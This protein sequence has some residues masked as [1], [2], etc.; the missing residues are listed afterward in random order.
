MI[1]YSVH[2]IAVILSV[3]ITYPRASLAVDYPDNSFI[4]TKIYISKG[5]DINELRQLGLPI[6]TTNLSLPDSIETLLNKYELEKLS[7]LGYRI[8]IINSNP[9]NNFIQSVKTKSDDITP[10][11]KY[12]RPGSMGGYFT[13]GEIDAEFERM[14]QLFT[15]LISGDTIGYSINGLP[16]KSY[17]FGS[18]SGGGVPNVLFTALH[19]GREPGGVSTIIYF[20]WDLLEKYERNDK[21]ALFLL[22]TRNLYVVPV[23]NPDGYLLNNRIDSNG[24]ARGGGLWRKNRRR[25]NDSV[26]GVDLNRNYGPLEFWNADNNGSEIAPTGSTYRGS[27]PFSEP[28]TRALRDLCIA[29]RFKTAINYDSSGEVIIL[30]YAA[31]QIEPEDSLLFRGLGKNIH[32]KSKYVFGFTDQVLSYSAR[33]TAEDYMYF[34]FGTIAA[35]P[36]IGNYEERFWTDN[37]QQIIDDAIKN[38][39]MNYQF[40]WS[41]GYN[42]R[43]NDIRIDYSTPD[44]PNMVV[45]IQNIG[46][47]AG[48]KPTNLTVTPLDEYITVNSPVRTILPLERAD[49]QVEKFRISAA[50]GFRNGRDVKFEIMLARDGIQSR[51]TFEFALYYP[52]ILDLFD[53]GAMSENWS[54]GGWGL[55]YDTSIGRDVLADSPYALYG[56]ETS[57]FL[58]YN[59]EISLLNYRNALLT[60]ETKWEVETKYDLCVVQASADGGATWEYLYSDRMVIGISTQ[61]GR[62][63]QAGTMGFHGYFKDYLVQECSLEKYIGSDILLRFGLLSDRTNVYNGWFLKSVAI[64]LFDEVAG[65][66]NDKSQNAGSLSISPSPVRRGEILIIR[67]DGLIG[68]ANIYESKINDSKINLIIYNILGNEVI[69]RRSNNFK[70]LNI[71]TD[72]LS[73]G[74][75]ILRVDVGMKRMFKR[76]L[77]V[78]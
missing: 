77:V 11:S 71:P 53:G 46:T 3:L 23:V 49:R 69:H 13:Y 75:Y 30:P 2:I 78:D 70:E 24:Y 10:N 4:K 1:K 6:H 20:L 22:N 29:K 76:I 61:K 65:V 32:G 41:A 60:L 47:A 14:K 16:I 27:S 33:G 34:T 62:I 12:Y 8:A 45:E 48:I 36:E 51:D 68:D 59:K 44:A 58:Y 50:G 42:L 38:L 39:Y 57:N 67:F 31:L 66:T 55:E 18:S 17:R 64:H 35:T 5:S 72:G 52:I 25:V 15:G 74:Q 26:Y 40:L 21:E 63:Q 73:P 56:K 19:H 37:P 28:E 9:E 43:P 7:A 54:S